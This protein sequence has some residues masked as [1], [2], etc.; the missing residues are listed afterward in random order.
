MRNPHKQLALDIAL[1]EDATFANYVGAAKH[2][3]DHPGQ[4]VFVWDHPRRV[5]VTCCRPAASGSTTLST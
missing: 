2:Q 1:R 5:A 4:L 3:L